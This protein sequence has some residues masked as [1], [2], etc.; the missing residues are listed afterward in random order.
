MDI[1]ST[2]STSSS[3]LFIY[4]LKLQDDKYY[5]GKV[6]GEITQRMEEHMAG[7]ASS[8]TQQHVPIEV[9]EIKTGDDYDEDKYVLKYMQKYGIDNVRGGSFNQLTLPFDQHVQAWKSIQ[10]ACGNCTVCGQN[11]HTNETCTSPICY[12]CGQDGH[13]FDKCTA[14]SHTMGGRVDGCFRCGRSDHWAIRCNRSKDFLGR[15]LNQ[16]ACAIQ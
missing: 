14:Q 4:V 6:V 12:R 3:Q 11:S 2:P 13:L 10:N 15:Q 5:V 7:K 16:N 1:P 8:W 9:M